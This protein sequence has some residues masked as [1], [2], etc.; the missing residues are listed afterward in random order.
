MM[1][2]PPDWNSFILATA[3][4]RCSYKDPKMSFPK[5]MSLP[6]C[7]CIARVVN[8]LGIYKDLEQNIYI[9]NQYVRKAICS[10]SDTSGLE[11]TWWSSIKLPYAGLAKSKESYEIWPSGSKVWPIG[12]RPVRPATSNRVGVSIP[13]FKLRLQVEGFQK[14]SAAII[15]SLW[16]F[17]PCL[18]N[19]MRLKISISFQNW[20]FCFSTFSN[21]HRYLLLFSYLGSVLNLDFKNLRS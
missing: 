18:D 7:N 13:N 8:F 14:C 15:L 21:Q 1:R 2:L 12:L 17:G 4:F 3:W 10:V 6:S 20:P 9:D 11:V 19:W 16:Y 5:K